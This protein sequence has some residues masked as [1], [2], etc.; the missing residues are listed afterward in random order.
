MIIYVLWL[1]AR[2]QMKYHFLVRVQSC[3]NNI[4]QSE[5]LC[6]VIFA[7]AFQVEKIFHRYQDVKITK[8]WQNVDKTMYFHHHLCRNGTSQ[9]WFYVL[10]WKWN[11]NKLVL[12]KSYFNL[13][14]YDT[15]P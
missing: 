13:D 3:W 5:G 12:N 14:V 4:K 6:D 9:F 1:K 7:G 2:S 15:G 11:L 8:L 10:L